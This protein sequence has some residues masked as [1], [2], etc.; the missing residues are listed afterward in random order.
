MT[1]YGLF[2][3]VLLFACFGECR[4]LSGSLGAS[5]AQLNAGDFRRAEAGF[6]ACLLVARDVGNPEV[7][8]VALKWLAQ[9]LAAQSREQH[10]EAFQCLET[11]EASLAGLDASVY[12]EASFERGRVS[13]V[14]AQ[15]LSLDLL[16]E[17]RQSR[18]AGI[19]RDSF[20]KILQNS[21]APAE[22]A[23]RRS[24]KFYPPELMAD[25]YLVN[26]DVAHLRLNVSRLYFP[27]RDLAGMYETVRAGYQRAVERELS[28]GED[29]RSDVV[30]SG[31]IG[32]GSAFRE[33]AGL[34]GGCE[35]SRD[36][37]EKAAV[38]FS[39]ALDATPQHR[40]LMLTA[41]MGRARSVLDLHEGRSLSTQ[42][43]QEL[44]TL[45]LRAADG[46]EEMRA[47]QLTGAT[48]QGAASFFSSRT[49]A[50]ETLLLLYEKMECPEK[51]LQA[52]ER[53]KA[54]S[55]SDLLSVHDEKEAVRPLDI[56]KT[57]ARLK[58]QNAGLVE[59][60]YGPEN[61]WVFWV[62]PDGRV[63]VRKLGM[64]GQELTQKISK[65]LRGFS[66]RMKL[67]ESRGL[68]SGVARPDVA[69]AYAVAAELYRELM[70]PIEEE[71]ERDG[72]DL[73]YIVPH[74]AMHYLPFQ[75]LVT[76]INKDR[77]VQSRFYVQTGRAL[78]YLPSAGTLLDIGAALQKGEALIF[79]RSDF[80]HQKPRYPNDLSNTVPEAEMVAKLLGTTP[81]LEGNATEETLRKN[82][83]E[84][85]VLYFATHGDLKRRSPLDTALLLAETDGGCRP[86][87]DGLLT[88]REI[89][90]ELRGHLK[91]E[92]TVMSACDTN[93]GETNPLSGDDISTL[94][95]AFLIAGSRS[96]LATQWEASDYTF[97]K[98]MATFLEALTGT[99]GSQR[100]KAEAL[101]L[102]M[103]TFLNENDVENSRKLR[104]PLFWAPVVLLGDG[105]SG[106]FPVCEPADQKSF[107]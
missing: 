25:V 22:E 96:V 89:L 100:R 13:L 14:K 79:A 59:F 55:F 6:R 20:F 70:E 71:I 101:S 72:L 94:S 77:L 99:D 54:R 90:N 10:P 86:D 69:D 58:E 41:A 30:A 23:L 1:R 48:L 66:R 53:M 34:I 74:H 97:P 5:V 43:E 42:V 33:E 28:R 49:V 7:E 37:L 36:L 93:R 52:V 102:A 95:R 16:R 91:N 44:E 47:S 88:V 60:F 15:L 18:L 62:S 9:S 39:K 35:R 26:S 3:I 75:A 40:E 63:T 32:V 12:P 87:C 11:A 24:E 31:W 38:A 78:A 65:M 19:E 17:L 51:M 64:T 85:S 84:H 2:L 4:A 76:N 80:T 67:L 103:R 92:L 45:L 29:A 98:I 50:Y 73:L 68:E 105:Y 82:T 57:A 107:E 106:I 83:G 21:M 81:F 56:K 61:V 46:Y 27:S 8:A 104:H